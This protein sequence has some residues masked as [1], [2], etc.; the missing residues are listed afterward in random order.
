MEDILDNKIIIGFDL[1][2]DYSQISYMYLNDAMPKTVSTS[3]GDEKFQIPTVLLKCHN[4]DKWYVGE[5]ALKVAKKEEGLMVKNI[6]QK[7]SEGKSVYYEGTEYDTKML[8]EIFIKRALGFLMYEGVEKIIPDAIM[9][10]LKQ[11][12]KPI[13][14]ALRHVCEKIGIDGENVYITTHEESFIDYTMAQ[15]EEIYKNDILLVEYEKECM[16]SMLLHINFKTQPVTMT[17]EAKSFDEITD[18]ESFVNSKELQNPDK[19]LDML[20]CETLKREMT[21]KMISCI[22]LIGGGFEN[23]WADN[24]YKYLCRRTRVFQGKNLFSKGACHG[25]FNKYNKKNMDYLY[26]GRQKLMVNV[27]MELIVDGI[28]KYYSLIS[29]GENWYEAKAECEI[30]LEDTDMLE[31]KLIPIDN[32]DV[33]TV[34]VQLFDMPKRPPKTNRIRLEIEFDSDNSG[35]IRA[36]DA[37]FGEFFKSTGRQ[38]EHRVVL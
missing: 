12:D 5:E 16:K 35:I 8:L 30:I 26:L 31:I 18:Y 37:G 2:D 15:P 22:F 32:K 11:A 23:N 3:Y 10:T 25:A 17:I 19:E 28:N 9:F 1:C 24:T 27:G 20:V 4:S 13:V 36:Y 33:R 29:A 7:C 6:L 38:W 14:N 21:G 34:I